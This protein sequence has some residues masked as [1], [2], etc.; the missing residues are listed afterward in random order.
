MKLYS[1]HLSCEPYNMDSYTSEDARKEWRRI[2]NEAERG[3]PVGVTRYGKRIAVVM[4]ASRYA[5]AM[6]VWGGVHAATLGSDGKPLPNDATITVGELHSAIG[7]AT[8]A[9]LKAQSPEEG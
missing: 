9:E 2:L 5:E 8:L 1:P 4:P 6:G 7:E 3:E